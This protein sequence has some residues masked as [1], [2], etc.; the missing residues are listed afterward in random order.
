MTIRRLAMANIALHTLGLAAAALWM[1]PGSPG[2][3]LA[4]RLAYLADRP[5]GWSIA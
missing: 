4:D 2:V 3:P 5:L 1:R